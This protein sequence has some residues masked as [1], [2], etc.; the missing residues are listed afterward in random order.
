MQCVHEEPSANTDYGSCAAHPPISSSQSPLCLGTPVWSFLA[1]FLAPPLQITPALLGCDLVP[2][3]RP[4]CHLPPLWGEGP[5]LRG[6]GCVRSQGAP[7]IAHP[8]P[9]PRTMSHC[10]IRLYYVACKKCKNTRKPLGLQ[11]LFPVENSVDILNNFFIFGNLNEFCTQKLC[12]IT[13]RQRE[14]QFI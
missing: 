14:V 9:H 7:A 8:L 11:A 2:V 12:A 4:F 13:S 10:S 5:P 1:R 3:A 6:G